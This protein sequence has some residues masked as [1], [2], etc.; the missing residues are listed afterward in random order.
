VGTPPGLWRAVQETSPLSARCRPVQG[1]GVGV[2]ASD[3]DK[4]L[5]PAAL[6]TPPAAQARCAGR[7]V[8]A[9]RE[10]S[11]RQRAAVRRTAASRPSGRSLKANVCDPGADVGTTC[12][13]QGQE[14]KQDLRPVP[15]VREEG[16]DNRAT[17]RSAGTAACAGPWGSDACVASERSSAWAMHS[18]ALVRRLLERPWRPQLPAAV[19][20]SGRT[21]MRTRSPGAVRFMCCSVPLTL[22]TERRA[23]VATRPRPPRLLLTRPHSHAHAD[24]AGRPCSPM[25]LTERMRAAAAATAGWLPFQAATPV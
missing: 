17:E 3:S 4:V 16:G 18:P 15:G 13:V 20:R 1:E 25:L 19:P 21:R 10:S 14:G 22:Q 6:L 23:H 8:L 12:A 9:G 2:S 24:Q 5:R 7:C 11:L